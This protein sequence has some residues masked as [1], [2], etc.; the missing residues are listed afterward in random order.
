MRV[1]LDRAFQDRLERARSIASHEILFEAL[2]D[3]IEKREKREKRKGLATPKRPRNPA[4]PRQPTPGLRAPISA[5]TKRIVFERD[6]CC[7]VF[8]GP[9]G[10]RCGSTWQLQYHHTT[11]APITGSSRPEDLELRCKPHDIYEAKLDYG[12]EFIERL[13]HQR[14]QSARSRGTRMVV[15]PV[16]VGTRRPRRQ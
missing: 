7:C 8:P 13:I 5:E 12:K 16:G 1:T 4:P 14:R 10:K 9:D 3:F 15:P 2:G 6:G 11:P